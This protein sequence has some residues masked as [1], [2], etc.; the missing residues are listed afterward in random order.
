MQ[1]IRVSGGLL[2]GKCSDGACALEEV[3]LKK[4]GDYLSKCRCTGTECI[5]GA[6]ALEEVK[7]KK[8]ADHQGK[9]RCTL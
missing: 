5:G 8:H 2:C 3:K 9:C 4:L 6:C 1:I 7:A